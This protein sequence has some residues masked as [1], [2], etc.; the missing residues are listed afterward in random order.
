MLSSS[1]LLG[2]LLA[3][4]PAVDDAII[5]I[6]VNLFGT[7]FVDDALQFAI[8]GLEGV[9]AKNNLTP[10]ALHGGDFA[11]KGSGRH[12]NPGLRTTLSG[13]QGESLSMIT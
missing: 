12:D 5:V 13:G 11:G 4:A 7:G 10:V 3:A 2:V 9:L 8:A 6:G 1:I